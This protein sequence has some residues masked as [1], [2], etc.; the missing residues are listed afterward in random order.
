MKIFFT[1]EGGIAGDHISLGCIEFKKWFFRYL[2]LSI[3]FAKTISFFSCLSLQD[4][5]CFCELRT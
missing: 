3:E 1:A 5:V 2:V 4:K